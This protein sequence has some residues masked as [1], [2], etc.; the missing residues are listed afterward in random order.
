MSDFVVYYFNGFSGRAQ[1][2][3]M[4]LEAA[5][6]SWERAPNPR[7]AE[8]T[9]FAVPAVRHGSTFL[10]QTTAAAVFLG[11]TLSIDFNGAKVALKPADDMKFQALKVAC[12]L[13][14]V[15]ADAYGARKAKQSWAAV[16]EYIAGRL[17]KWLATLEANRKAWGVP[18]GFLIGISPTYLDFLLFNVLDVLDFMFGS[19]MATARGAF[20]ELYRISDAIAAL[21]RM[22]ALLAKEAVLYESV[23]AAGKMPF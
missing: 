10:S 14:D 20:P 11:E 7:D 3:D 5:G 6:V 21:P 18:G 12:D 1:P 13:A 15:W 2:L 16:D 22:S 8:P 9:A 4:M 19:G 23:S 17:T